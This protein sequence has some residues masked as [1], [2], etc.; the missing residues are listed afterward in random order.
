MSMSLLE[1]VEQGA[2][3][4]WNM[5]ASP[6]YLV[7]SPRMRNRLIHL[8]RVSAL[9]QRY[10]VPGYKIRRVHLCKIYVHRTKGRHRIKQRERREARAEQRMIASL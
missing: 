1:M 7:I 9:Y 2:R 4:L 3:N 8:E 6:G 10:P 5:G